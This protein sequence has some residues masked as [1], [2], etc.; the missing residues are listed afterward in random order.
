MPNNLSDQTESQGFWKL[1]SRILLILSI[2]SIVKALVGGHEGLW[3]YISA[4]SNVVWFG[5]GMI[6]VVIAVYLWRKGEYIKE[7]HKKEEEKQKIENIDKVLR[8]LCV[9]LNEK[10]RGQIISQAECN[11][12]IETLNN[13]DVKK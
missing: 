7:K 4:H 1:L 10:E 9:W 8:N 2:V 5:L 6:G 12:C 11:S 13:T 3:T